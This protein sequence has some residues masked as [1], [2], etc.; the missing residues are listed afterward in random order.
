MD[1]PGSVELIYRVGPSHERWV[2]EEDDVPETWLHDAIIDLLKAV[3]S[4]WVSR[5]GVEPPRRR[6]GGGP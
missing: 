5:S 3:L 2:L 4:A 1:L 6:G